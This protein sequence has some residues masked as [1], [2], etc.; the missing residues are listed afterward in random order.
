MTHQEYLEPRSLEE[1]ISMLSE[2]GE[3]ARVF[4]GGTDLLVKMKK[5]VLLP[6]YLINIKGIKCSLRKVICSCVYL[7]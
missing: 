2:Y 6:E 1:A 3:N 5:K 4:A 7:D